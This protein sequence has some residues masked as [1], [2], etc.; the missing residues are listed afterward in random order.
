MYV[1]MDVIG[2]GISARVDISMMRGSNRASVTVSP[3][4]NSNRLTLNG[5]ILPK[6][7]SSVFKGNSL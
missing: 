3:N 5:V 1:S 2:I 4:F 7:R 6:E